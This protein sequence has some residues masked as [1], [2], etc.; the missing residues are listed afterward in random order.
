M[1]YINYDKKG[2][3]VSTTTTDIRSVKAEEGATVFKVHSLVS[4]GKKKNDFE[5]DMTYRCEGNKFIIDMQT[6]LNPEQMAAYK[7]ASLVVETEDM[8][9]PSDLEPGMELNDGFIEVMVRMDYMT[10]EINARAF[11]REV[12][13]KEEV[14]VPAG[15]FEA[16]KIEGNVESKFAFM[17][18]AFRT[19]EWYVE[20]VG[21]VKSESYD[22]KGKK[23]G[24]SELQ[25]IQ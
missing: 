21:V 4:T 22:N 11:Y 20:N 17:R 6:L 3:E 1:T 5:M 13:G 2:K 7:D 25:S 19:V 23:M 10:T 14:T 8:F 9:I 18:F 24:Y 16:W 15:T 12:I